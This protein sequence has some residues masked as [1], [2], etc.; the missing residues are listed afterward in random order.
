MTPILVGPIMPHRGYYAW[1]YTTPEGRLRRSRR[2]L[3]KRAADRARG[4]QAEGQ[5]RAGLQVLV[6]DD[7]V[8]LARLIATHGIAL[9]APR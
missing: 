5:V 8:G 1:P 6:S 7:E 4:L 3:D 9:P 2:Y